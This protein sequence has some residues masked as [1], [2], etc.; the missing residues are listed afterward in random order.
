M[1]R[2]SSG[3]LEAPRRDAPSSGPTS[4]HAQYDHDDG[5]DADSTDSSQ[6]NENI[7]SDFDNSFMYMNVVVNKIK[8]A[9][10]LDSGS[11]INIMSESLFSR[12]PGSYKRD[13]D[14]ECGDSLKLAN[15]CTISFVC[16]CQVKVKFNS[17][18]AKWIPVFVIKESAHAL[19]LGT[20]FMRKN[21]IALDFSDKCVKTAVNAKCQSTFE[22]LPNTEHVIWAKVPK[23]IPVGTQCLCSVSHCLRRKNLLVAKAVV[24]VNVD[25]VVPVKLLNPG[26]AVTIFKGT[27]VASMN[28]LDY[29]Y[30]VSPFNIGSSDI[31]N[32]LQ[33]AHVL[34]CFENVMGHSES[35]KNSDVN[36]DFDNGC[37]KKLSC[38]VSDKV[39]NVD[40]TC[41]S[42]SEMID[43]R[44]NI[45]VSQQSESSKF[46]DNFQLNVDHLD[47][48]QRQYLCD[49]LFA[50][51]DIFVTEDNPSLGH[52]NLVEHHIRLKPNAKSCY[53]RAHRLSPE[54][55]EVLRFQL[56][57]LLKQ[58]IIA[59]V[60]DSE[61]SPITS[62]MLLVSKVRNRS[63]VKSAERESA[64]QEALHSYRFC[65]DFRYL[66]SQ[67]EEFRYTLPD[68][69]DLTESF[70]S[71][72][73]NFLT[74]IDL[75][76][77]FFQ[78]GIS[79]ESTKY[80]AFNTCFG[81]YKF[82][83]LPMGLR[84]SPNTF[85]L[86]MDKV[87]RGLTF[88]AV[89]CYLDD[90][91][92]ISET[93][94]EHMKVLDEIFRRFKAAGLELNPRKCKFAQSEVCYLGHT[95]SRKGISPPQDRV[96]AIKDFARPHNIKSLRRF[97]GMVGWFRKFI[98]NFGIVAE[99][100]YY[101]LRK[102]VPF[103]WNNTQQSAF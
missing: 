59:P 46:L 67:M 65:C 5:S 96:E 33:C 100:L 44:E 89:L 83:R 8:V 4:C 87:L 69:E 25:H 75:S 12:L 20:S 54:K 70:S 52:T 27:N 76:S 97:L 51:R 13:I 73:P 102:D 60:S 3:K 15:A 47:V 80:T 86:L 42:N 84:T 24:V 79:Q 43:C 91:L 61:D 10:L 40:I 37:Y 18:S 35:D 48:N 64:R 32:D 45:G 36:S 30:H 14:Y 34:K 26:D 23:E 78:M 39:H 28:V 82:L 94:D 56:D 81:T 98:P 88:Q 71:R 31:S 90:V 6:D 77:G 99:P 29:S 22:L 103:V 55:K 19:I 1:H 92:C 62:P 72:T 101:L 95:I 16:H 74:S 49:T 68:L 50:N 2:L 41:D 63:K 58:G 57:E 9:A 85:Q 66:N 11:N 17:C 93:F 38:N 21:N 7:D 53:Q